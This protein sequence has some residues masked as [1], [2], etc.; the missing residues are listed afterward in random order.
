MIGYGNSHS[1]LFTF[2]TRPG[3]GEEAG[4]SPKD[5]G[6]QQEPPA[7]SG[8]LEARR[9][10]TPTARAGG[11]LTTRRRATLTAR[12]ADAAGGERSRTAVFESLDAIVDG[13]RRIDV[14]AVRH[15]RFGGACECPFCRD[16]PFTFS[17]RDAMSDPRRNMESGVPGGP[18]CRDPPFTFGP[19]SRYWTSRR[20]LSWSMNQTSTR[21]PTMARTG[22]EACSIGSPSVRPMT[23]YIR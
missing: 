15:R 5:G 18:I 2:P 4:Y 9:Q 6:A 3:L 10:A 16:P 17:G 14:V 23:T 20:G 22:S 11:R 13:G 12:A 19:G 7:R 1:R 21:S 8:C